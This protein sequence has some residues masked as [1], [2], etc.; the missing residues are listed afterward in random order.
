MAIGAR[1]RETAMKWKGLCL[2]ACLLA[3]AGLARGGGLPDVAFTDGQFDPA[4][5]EAAV[6]YVGNGGDYGV[7]M[8]DTG[9]NPGAFLRTR[10]DVNAHSGPEVR[11]S[12]VVFFRRIGLEYDPAT[13][14]EIASLDYTEDAI[15]LSGSVQ[16]TGLV[17]WQDGRAYR[18]IVTEFR[19]TT[20]EGESLAG[21]LAEDL[22]GWVEQ[23][24][25][26]PDFS[27]SGS[28][29]EFGFF[30]GL[31]TTDIPYS[32]TAGI[33]NWSTTIHRVPEPATVFLVVLGAAALLRPRQRR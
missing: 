29:L 3:A 11:T 12:T 16:S 27:E 26:H 13:Q 22:F 9:G 6:V 32:M 2:G 17:V 21:V 7:D 23:R 5:W 15:M 28:P 30:R 18:T 33:D 19:Q 31:S 4:D 14:G 24:D 20:W 8:Q 10:L 25:I 1:E